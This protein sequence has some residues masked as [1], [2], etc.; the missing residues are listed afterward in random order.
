MS[1]L[2]KIHDRAILSRRVRLTVQDRPTY[3]A[4]FTTSALLTLIFPQ[5]DERSTHTHIHAYG[6][7]LS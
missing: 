3:C 7:V 2:H 5:S 6:N 1:A 4:G